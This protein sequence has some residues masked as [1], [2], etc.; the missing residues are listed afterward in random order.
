MCKGYRV[1]YFQNICSLLHSKSAAMICSAVLVSYSQNLQDSP[2]AQ[3]VN[4]TCC[5]ETVKCINFEL[6]I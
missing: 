3:T 2:S 6:D 4:H 5:S 1:A